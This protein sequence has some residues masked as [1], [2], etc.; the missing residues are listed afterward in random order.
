MG[1]NTL[2]KIQTIFLGKLEMV[3]VDSYTIVQNQGM[4]K[5]G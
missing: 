1:V 3:N 5:L 4:R 2:K